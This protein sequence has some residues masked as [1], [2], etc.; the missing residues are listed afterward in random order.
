MEALD[1]TERACNCLR[2]AG[3]TSLGELVK[4][5]RDDLLS[6]R[7]MGRTTVRVIEKALAAR[8]LHLGMQKIDLSTC[9]SIDALMRSGSQS[10]THWAATAVEALD[11]TERAYNCLRGAGITSLG[12]LVK[13][14]PDDLLSIRA[15]GRTTVRV[16]EEALAARGLHLGM[17]EIDLSTCQSIDAFLHA[18]GVVRDHGTMSVADLVTK[19]PQEVMTL[20]GV[21]AT[22][23]R[24]IEDGLAKWGL[25][26]GMLSAREPFHGARVA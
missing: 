3:I 23:V 22:A 1:L 10:A 15:M 5:T 16:I 4:K 19:T 26:L 11:F 20:P 7:A 8:G 2:R 9:Q 13:K 21:D 25:S 17:Q 12:E 14:T 18:M 6:I 24:Q